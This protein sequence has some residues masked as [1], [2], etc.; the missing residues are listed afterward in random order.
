MDLHSFQPPTATIS[1]TGKRKNPATATRLA[2]LTLEV[3]K[4]TARAENGENV[5]L[6]ERIYMYFD[7]ETK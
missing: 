2:K 4:Q 3:E 1:Q 5:D 7:E 6:V